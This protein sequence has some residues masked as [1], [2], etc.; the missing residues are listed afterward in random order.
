[1]T[2]HETPEAAFNAAKRNKTGRGKVLAPF[3]LTER[4]RVRSRLQVWAN[5]ACYSISIRLEGPDD[6]RYFAFTLTPKAP[7]AKPTRIEEGA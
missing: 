4:A 3:N 5:K 7:K 6:A 2:T 1:M